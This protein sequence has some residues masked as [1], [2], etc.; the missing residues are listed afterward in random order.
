MTH[1]RPINA[2]RANRKNDNKLL[3]PEEC[4][5]DALADLSEGKVKATSALVLLLDSGDDG[6]SYGVHFRACRLKSSE[7]LS[8]LEVAKVEVLKSMNYI[9]EIDS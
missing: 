9:P 7:M 4:L 5:Q 8:L 6:R 3:S 2:L 1:A